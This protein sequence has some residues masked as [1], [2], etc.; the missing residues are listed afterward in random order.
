LSA[1][2]MRTPK[3]AP[4]DPVMPMMRRRIQNSPPSRNEAYNKRTKIARVQTPIS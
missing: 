4:V 3:M 1:S 2:S